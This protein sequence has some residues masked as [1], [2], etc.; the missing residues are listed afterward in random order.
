MRSVISTRSIVVRAVVAL[1]VAA[2]L[3][4]AGPIVRSSASPSHAKSYTFVVSNNFLGN[5]WRPQVERLAQLTANY[6]PFKGRVTVKIDNAANTTQAQIASLNDIIATHPDAILLIAGSTTALDPVVTRACNAGIVVVTVSGPVTAKCAYNVNQNFY[7]GMTLVGK[8]M[9]QVLHNQGS[10]FVDRGLPGLN[11]SND[12]KNGFL[13]GLKK[14]GPNV[15]D[16]G[17]FDGNYAQGPEQQGISSLLVGHPSVNGVMTQGYCTPVFNAFRNAGKKAV[18]ATCYAYNGE[19]VACKRAHHQ[20]AILS[21]SPI[22]MQICMKLALNILDGQK[23]A[24]PGTVVGMPLWLYVTNLSAVHL[25]GANI[26]IEQIKLGKNA[27]P[28]LP[29][30]LA[31]PIT[32]PQYPITP[33]QAA[34]K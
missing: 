30:G 5:D 28:N 21:G 3:A 29:P 11:I 22:V 13:A 26:H 20:C 25:S 10:V 18:P 12:I 34:G 23:V 6:P 31:L 4:L 27:F 33:K 16:I 14:T 8:W 9:G 2:S 19:L 32:L 1:L 17:E 7:Y 24:K 15:K